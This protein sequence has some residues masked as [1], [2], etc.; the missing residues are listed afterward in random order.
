MVAACER[1]C[2]AGI[3]TQ[4]STR[5]LLHVIVSLLLGQAHGWLVARVGARGSADQEVAVGGAAVRTRGVGSS[6]DAP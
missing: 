5:S 2:R 1:V 6:A 3:R 4:D